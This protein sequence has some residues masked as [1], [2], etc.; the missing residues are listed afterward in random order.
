M[1]NSTEVVNNT[2]DIQNISSNQVFAS[3]FLFGLT[4]LNNVLL[5]AI[6]HYER[7]G[8]DPQ[9]R[10]LGNRL[11]SAIFWTLLFIIDTQFLHLFDHFP[12]AVAAVRR[13]LIIS[14]PMFINLHS[15]VMYLQVVVFR[16]VKEIND[17]LAATCLRRAVH[18]GSL[19]FSVTFPLDD[20]I[21]E[22]DMDGYETG[23]KVDWSCLLKP[24]KPR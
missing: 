24:L 22:S 4:A 8:G 15:M 19:W 7:F 23:N 6:I 12:W 1:L 14:V 17:E 13:S 11:I 10:G 2:S 3:I 9:K 21:M 20:V 18:L 16:Q 5:L